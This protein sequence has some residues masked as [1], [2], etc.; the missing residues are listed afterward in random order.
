MTESLSTPDRLL[1]AAARLFAERGIDNVSVAEIVRAADQ[2]NPSAVRY[3]F[4]TA[5]DLLEAIMARHVPAIA[6]RRRELIDEARHQGDRDRVSAAAAIVLPVTDLAQRGWRERAYLRIGSE[7]T[8]ALERY[9][10]RIQELLARTE[11]DEAWE[12]LRERCP[13]V[14]TDLWRV[15]RELCIV[16]VGRAAADWARLLDG[17]D[18]DT[19]D[20]VLPAD[21]FAENLIEMVLGA[22]T[23]PHADIDDR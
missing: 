15:R 11:G 4:G 21:R 6:G 23:A 8:G 5:T 19:G 16:F 2:R 1:D 9:P 20:G 3:H 10:A 17:P 7:M 14:P 22:M 12:L 13:E 18:G